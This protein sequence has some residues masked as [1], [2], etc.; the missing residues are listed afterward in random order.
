MDACILTLDELKNKEVIN[1][2]DGHRLGFVID[3]QLDVVSG[4][5]ISIIVPGEC[6][7]LGISKGEDCY[8]IIKAGSSASG[9]SSAIA[10]A[11]D[12]LALAEEMIAAVRKAYDERK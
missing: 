5:L 8:N 6:N 11:A 1:V 9:C 3:G 2:C 7:F 10:K 4:R 12:P